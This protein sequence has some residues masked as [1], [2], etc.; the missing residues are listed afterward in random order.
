ML[1][2]LEIYRESEHDKTIKSNKDEDNIKKNTGPRSQS[3]QNGE[4]SNHNMSFASLGGKRIPQSCSRKYNESASKVR[5]VDINDIA[6][7]GEL[8]RYRLIGYQYNINKVK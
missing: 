8:L 4:I 5:K 7:Y 3:Q 6:I 2:G 1:V